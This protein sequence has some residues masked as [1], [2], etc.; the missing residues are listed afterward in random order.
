MT[1]EHQNQK[2]N[3]A[4]KIEEQIQ[5][6]LYCNTIDKLSHLGFDHD[7]LKMFKNHT[8][9][10]LYQD[11]QTFCQEHFNYEYDERDDYVYGINDEHNT[12]ILKALNT[13]CVLK[14]DREL[15]ETRL[16][17]FICD[18]LRSR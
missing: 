10:S 15:K 14:Y 12:V 2:E 7:Y 1:L 4:D 5:E 17:V 16:T 9:R 18:D 8:H 3:L 6:R 13:E 11:T